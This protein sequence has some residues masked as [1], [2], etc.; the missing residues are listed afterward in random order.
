MFKK[1]ILSIV[2]MLISSV[3]ANSA[4]ATTEEALFL[5]NVAKQYILAQFT[6]KNDNIRYNIKVSKVDRNRDFGGKCSGYLSAKLLTPE[7]KKNSIV[8]VICKREKN[9]YSIQIPVSIIVQRAT[10][11]AS[12]NIPRGSAITQDM[13]EKKFV[14]ENLILNQSITDSSLIIG[15]KTKKDIRAGEYLKISDLC[16]VAKGDVVTI[17]ARS[18][19]LE[20]KATGIA[21][22]EGKLNE[23]IAVK[24]M[25]S[26]KIIRALVRS[27]NS[28]EVVF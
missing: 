21:M 5:E 14:N 20:I 9:P 3:F 10:I 18:H 6:E 19:G 26:G 23:T 8:K 4:F 13:L 1:K 16:L 7:I 2:T 22:E 24:N 17:S 15:S 11:V 27:A 28:V 12:D 25:K